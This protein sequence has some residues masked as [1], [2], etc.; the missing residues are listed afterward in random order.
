MEINEERVVAMEMWIDKLRDTVD[1]LQAEVKA[2][3]EDRPA[4]VDFDLLKG[5]VTDLESRN[6]DAFEDRLAAV[7]A[8]VKT[9]S[10][11][12]LAWLEF[13]VDNL[14]RGLHSF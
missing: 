10:H 8:R 13:A 2:L 7:E 6:S 12:R 11:Q 5:R 9:P 14:K 1:A 4:L 3:K